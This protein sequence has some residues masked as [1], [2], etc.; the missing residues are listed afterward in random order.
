VEPH[1]GIPD[2]GVVLVS[3]IVLI[4]AALVLYST[5]VF[6]ERRA[7]SLRWGH[8]GLF[9]AGLAFDTAGTALMGMIAA[10]T[11]LGRT[12]GPTGVLN[13]VMAST[14]ATALALMAIH[15]GWALVVLIRDREA[16]RLTFHRFSLAV[17]GLW[18]VPYITGALG[19]AL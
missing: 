16:E 17:W 5:G 6:S 2:H 8:V 15:F 3:A 14:G 4:T 19:S 10:D 18:L 12:G 7:G 11:G 9:G 1:A 13:G